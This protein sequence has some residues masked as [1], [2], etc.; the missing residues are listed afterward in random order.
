MLIWL[1][2]VIAGLAAATPGTLV[3][4]A[5]QSSK[6]SLC[7]KTGSQTNP[8]VFITVA[9]KG[10]LNAHLG[11]P[12]DVF[13]VS[14]PEDCAGGDDSPTS[15][16][17]G[18][19]TPPVTMQPSPTPLPSAT[20]SPTPIY[21]ATNICHATGDIDQPYEFLTLTD[22]AAYQLHAS[23]PGDIF[24]VETAQDCPSQPRKFWLEH[25]EEFFPPHS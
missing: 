14:S 19:I 5:K 2:T 16:E 21:E 12:D 13:D 7:H 17:P 22:D 18:T 25:R 10:A 23:H 15:S 4:E 9:Q 11:H 20:P 8:Y 24:D 3:A 1:V 6:V